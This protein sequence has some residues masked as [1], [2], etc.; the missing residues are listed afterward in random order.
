MSGLRADTLLTASIQDLLF[1]FHTRMQ[2]A[3]VYR[4]RL[5]E[6]GIPQW[7]WE[8]YRRELTETA[9]DIRAIVAELRRRGHSVEWEE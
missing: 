5:N 8:L 3:E 2:Q 4:E 7:R 6:E 9:A 1:G